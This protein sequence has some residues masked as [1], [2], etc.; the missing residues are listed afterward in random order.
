MLLPVEISNI[1]L[2][3]RTLFVISGDFDEVFG[4]HP[5]VRSGTN[6]EEKNKYYRSNFLFV[7]AGNFSGY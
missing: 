3:S 7:P 2:E 4:V 6:Q 1:V 5:T